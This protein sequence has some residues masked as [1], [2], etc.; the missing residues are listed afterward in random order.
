[1][2]FHHVFQLFFLL[3]IPGYL[4]GQQPLYKLIPPQYELEHLQLNIKQSPGLFNDLLEDKE[5]YL[6]L[7]STNG[8]HVFDGHTTVTY[9]NGNKAFPISR[10]SADNIFSYF[11]VDPSGNFRGLEGNKNII[12]FNPAKRSLVDSFSKRQSAEHTFFSL[13]ASAGHGLIFV[14]LNKGKDKFAVCRKTGTAGFQ[15]LFESDIDPTSNIYTSLVGNNYWLF[16]KSNIIRLS[17]DNNKAERYSYPGGAVSQLFLYADSTSLYFTD[18]KQQAI[19]SWNEKTNKMEFFLALPPLIA[20][21]IHAFYVNN[22][23]LF[24]G[25]N[26]NLFIIDKV[27]NTLQDLSPQFTELAKK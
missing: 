9:S 15:I 7:P 3:T 20:G 11:S 17:L 14:Q 26:L 10:D 16:H 18:S 1:L 12:Q 6:W 25:S 21:K 24:I 19:Y 13:R 2:S 22:D 23:V 27:N 4:A 8:L 5:G